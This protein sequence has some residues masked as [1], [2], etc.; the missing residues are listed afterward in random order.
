[1]RKT[2]LTLGIIFLFISVC[3]VQ[4]TANDNK[5]I[6]DQ[7][8]KAVIV[9]K[10]A[11]GEYNFNLPNGARIDYLFK[12]KTEDRLT[13]FGVKIT[14]EWGDTSWITPF[15]KNQ[16]NFIM[17]QNYVVKMLHTSLVIFPQDFKG[18]P[19]Y[20]NDPLGGTKLFG[21]GD[22]IKVYQ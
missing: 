3:I 12:I 2:I 13:L 9:W 19:Y 22:V 4:V 5:E 21:Y 11:T 14:S 15:F 8:P 6:K 1:M 10:A 7:E 17:G 16:F 20:I 18:R